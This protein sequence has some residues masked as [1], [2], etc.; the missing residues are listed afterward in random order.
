MATD[1]RPPTVSEDLR[2]AATLIESAL[3]RMDTRQT[4][5]DHCG[6][7]RHTDFRDANAVDQLEPSIAK[8][9]RWANAFENPDDYTA[10]GEPVERALARTV[11]PTRRGA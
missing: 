5:C 4:T 2:L 3:S 10:R 9:R 8:L 1:S 6:A 7:R 11:R